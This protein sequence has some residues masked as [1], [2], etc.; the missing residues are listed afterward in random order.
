MPCFSNGIP[1]QGLERIRAASKLLRETT[2]RV[3]ASAIV[4]Q[5]GALAPVDAGTV[6]V[7]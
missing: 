2:Y 5:L 4:D 6:D 7:D 3:P 1:K